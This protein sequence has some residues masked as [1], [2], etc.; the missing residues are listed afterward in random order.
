M[1]FYLAGAFATRKFLMGI[2]DKI[3]AKGKHLCV[4]GWLEPGVRDRNIYDDTGHYIRTWSLNYAKGDFQDIDACDVFIL[5]DDG[6][7]STGGRNVELGYALAQGKHIIRVGP[8]SNIFADALCDDEFYN[9]A[10]CISYL[11]CGFT[12]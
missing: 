8:S 5:S 9:W 7:P 10:D 4:S 6:Y 2:R 1:K 12:F 11:S 3:E